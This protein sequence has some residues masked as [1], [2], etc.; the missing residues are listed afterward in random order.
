M[1]REGRPTTD[2]RGRNR[3]EFM[4]RH[5]ST[6]IATNYNESR[7]HVHTQINHILWIV[8]VVGFGLRLRFGKKDDERARSERKRAC[9]FVAFLLATCRTSDI[10]STRYFL[11]QCGAAIDSRLTIYGIDHRSI[12]CIS[13]SSVSRS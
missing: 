7:L 2:S 5:E 12:N 8:A 6:R 1:S 11:R 4:M 13:P 9:F 3:H 10:G